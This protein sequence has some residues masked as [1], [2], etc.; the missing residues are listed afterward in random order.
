MATT[1]EAFEKFARVFKPGELIFKQGDPGEH[2]FIVQ[3][4][5]IELFLNTP[6]G[7]KSLAY[8]VPGEFF[9]EMAIIDKASRSANARAVEETRLIMLDERTFDL[10]VQANPAIVRK[11]M[12]TMSSN[13]RAMNEQIT[14]LLIKDI[15]KRIANRILSVSHQHGQKTPTGIKM[16]IPYGEAELAKDTGL[17]DEVGKVHEVVEK[18]RASK[19][20][21]IQNGQIIVVS[22]E[23]LEKLH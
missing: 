16:A 4:G 13:I 2:M 5:R 15:N 22:N 20:I 19:I 18:L 12:K 17:V 10:H 1:Q 11:I 23:S 9:G 6:K 8:K 3:G 7:E 21:D 14:N